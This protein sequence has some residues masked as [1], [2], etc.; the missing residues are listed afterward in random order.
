MDKILKIVTVCSVLLLLVYSCEKFDALKENWRP[1]LAVPLLY[2]SVD[3]YD[4]LAKANR[5]DL[6]VINENTGLLALSYKG[7]LLSSSP[8]DIVQLPDQSGSFT[9][10]SPLPVMPIS[11][12]I[13]EST[14]QTQS[15]LPSGTVELTK[16]I[17]RSGKLVYSLGSS[18]G[19]SGSVDF[20][21]VA[22]SNNGS[23]F[24]R[25][26]SLNTLDTVDLAGFELDLSKTSQGFNE[27]Q[28]NITATISG[29][30][31][32]PIPS[33]MATFSVDMRGLDFEELYGDFKTQTVTSDQDSIL[34][35]LFG[36]L[37]DVG[38]ITF[39]DPSIHLF[40]SNSFGFPIQISFDD[41][42]TSN[43]IS[44]DTFRLSIDP[45]SSTFNIDYPSASRIGDSVSSSITFNRSNSSV[46]EIVRPTPKWL[47]SN[48][49]GVMN[50][51]GVPAQNHLHRD[52]GLKIETELELPL[53]GRVF[54]YGIRDTTEYSFS[55]SIDDIDSILVRANIINGFPIDAQVQVYLTDEN[56]NIT[57]SIFPSIEE[58]L[59]ASGT[60]NSKG[61][62]SQPAI[63]VTDVKLQKDRVPNILNAAYLITDMR[64]RTSDNGDVLVKIFDDY[65][66]S[67]KIGL[68]VDGKVP[69]GDSEGD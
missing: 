40:A 48:V 13:S 58:N 49:S 68:K 25:T 59:I 69:L 29:S 39:Q 35:K 42:Y 2:T 62:V 55:E 7:E 30:A 65:E 22:L 16:I 51:D 64:L 63:K 60:I 33:P 41:L 61:R 8:L 47:V 50:P 26:V 38:Q 28:M 21:I 52:A 37:K 45:N 10:N 12:T 18:F 31:G 20:S 4:I 53:T 15:F 6:F 32:D 17:F 14:T 36:Q 56:F 46:E 9:I 19:G 24:Q 66:I 5:N 1:S 23:I 44:G 34:I 57:D 43:A 54:N 67:T 11:G 27:F 3:V